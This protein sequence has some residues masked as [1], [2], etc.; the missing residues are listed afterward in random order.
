MTVLLGY[1]DILHCSIAYT[2][3]FEITEELPEL[4]HNVLVPIIVNQIM[5]VQKS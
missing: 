3:Y 5:C 2:L 1:I 4:K